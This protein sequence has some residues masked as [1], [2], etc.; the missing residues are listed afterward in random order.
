MCK[1]EI[2]IE[3]AVE[4]IARWDQPS[5]MSLRTVGRMIERAVQLQTIGF[6]LN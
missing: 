1:A 5:R 3:A 6:R 2:S 4:A